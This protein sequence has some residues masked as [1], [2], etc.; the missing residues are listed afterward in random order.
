MMTNKSFAKLQADRRT[1][2]YWL[3][4][5]SLLISH[6]NVHPSSVFSEESCLSASRG[7]MAIL[8]HTGSGLSRILVVGRGV[9]NSFGTCFGQELPRRLCL[10]LLQWKNSTNSRLSQDTPDIVFPNSSNSARLV[11]IVPK[12]WRTGSGGKFRLALPSGGQSAL[13][14][15]DVPSRADAIRT[16][17]DAVRTMETDTSVLLAS[18]DSISTRCT[19]TTSGTT[20]TM[21][22]LLHQL[23]HYD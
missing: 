21:M 11:H 20:A 2:R 5:S 6:T 16:L 15:G 12:R 9:G 13:W 4:T 10:G 22:L 19:N 17:Q 7:I 1:V 3:P 14:A 23:T 18:V 8:S